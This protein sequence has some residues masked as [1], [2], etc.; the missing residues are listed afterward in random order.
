MVGGSG[1]GRGREGI[2]NSLCTI[3]QVVSFA[4]SQMDMAYIRR[5]VVEAASLA[6]EATQLC[7]KL[8]E[9]VAQPAELFIHIY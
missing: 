3:W 5:E 4:L 1:A 8:V 7:R 9:G 2:G 6:R